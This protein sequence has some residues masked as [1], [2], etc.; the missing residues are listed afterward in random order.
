MEE[1]FELVSGERLP[2]S[3]FK[4]VH[5]ILVMP[6]GRVLIRRKHGEA[7]IT[8]G[9]IEQGDNG[10]YNALKRE[11]L[12]ELNCVV[13]RVEY[14]GYINYS[15]FKTGEHEKQARMVARVAEILPAKADPDR[16]NN[17]IYGRELLPPELAKNEIVNSAPAGNTAELFDA[18]M[19]VATENGFF[20]QPKNMKAEIINSESFDEV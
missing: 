4:R 11:V 18:C 14:V 17:W 12:E 19:E 3:V 16:T 6:D 8:G 7:R 15:N 20:D 1:E 5:A 9:H 10:I 2:D 13:D